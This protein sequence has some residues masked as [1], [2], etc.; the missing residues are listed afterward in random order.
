MMLIIAQRF[1]KDFNLVLCRDD[2]KRKL[3]KDLNS[4]IKSFILIN[5][6]TNELNK[7]SRLQCKKMHNISIDSYCAFL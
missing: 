5:I 1:E 7:S 4:S 6:T 2:L 3:K